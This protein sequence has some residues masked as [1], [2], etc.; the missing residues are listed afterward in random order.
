MSNPASPDGKLLVFEDFLEHLRRQG[1]TIGVDHYLRLQH[2]LNRVSDSCAPSDLKTLLCPILA[3]SQAEQEQFYRAFDT[4]F[5]VFHPTVPEVKP[6]VT[7]AEA[8][9]KVTEEPKLIAGKKWPY[10]LAGTLVVA[11]VFTLI[12]FLNQPKP[13]T[14]RPVDV[15]EN[16]Q[17]NTNTSTGNNQGVPSPKPGDVPADDTINLPLDTQPVVK[18]SFYERYGSA[19]RVG[20]IIVPVVFFLFYEWYRFNRRKLLLQKQRG[21]KPPYVWPLR[22]QPPPL[23]LYDSA[24]F[25]TT[26]RLMRRRQVGEFQRLDVYGTVMATINSLG[27]PNFRYKADSKYPEYL[28]LIDRAS[29][30]D[31]QAQ[32]FNQLAKALE[33]EAVFVSR[34]FYD[35][36][37]RVCRNETG[38]SF[39]LEE[40]RNKHVGQRLLIFGNGEKI[41]DPLTGSLTAWSA[42]FSDWPDRAV[43]TPELPSQWGLREITLAGQFIL[44]PATVDGLLAVVDHFESTLLTDLRSWRQ[45]GV[46]LPPRELDRPGVAEALRRYLGEETFNWLCACAVYPELHWDLTLYLGSLPCMP[47]GL[48]KEENLLRLIR[49]P[50]FRTGSMPDE[51]R[52]M[53]IGELD[54]EKEKVIRSAIINLLEKNPPAEGTVAADVYQL[55]LVV[56][57][58]LYRRE[59]KRLRELLRVLEPLPQNQVSRDYT[60]LRFLES[61]QN[62]PLHIFLPQQMRR[63]FYRNGIPVFGLKTVTRFL[64]TLGFSAVVALL[65]Y[66]DFYESAFSPG[67]ISLA[68]AATVPPS[69]PIA[70]KANA[71]SCSNCHGVTKSMQDKCIGCHTTQEFVPV[72][73]QSHAREKI[74]CTSCHIEHQGSS[75]GNG[76]LMMQVCTDC[77]NGTYTIKTG[78]RAGT[79]LPIAHGGD[80]G[81]PVEN[82]KWK[83]RLSADELRARGLPET[84]AGAGWDPDRQFHTIHESGRM[85]GRMSCKDC[86]TAGPVGGAVFRRTPREV[87]ATC[88]NITYTDQGAERVKSNCYT[89]HREHGTRSEDLARL[90]EDGKD[91]RKL[92]D[93]VDKLE[94]GILDSNERLATAGVFVEAGGAG[95]IRQ[96]R[97]AFPGLA[98]SFGGMTLYVWAALIGIISI[99]VLLLNRIKGSTYKHGSHR[100][101]THLIF[102]LMVLLLTAVAILGLKRYGLGENLLGLLNMRWILGIV[103]L[104]CIPVLM[105]YPVGRQTLNRQAGLSRYWRLAHSYLGIIASII[106]ILHSGADSGGLLTKALLTS[107]Y[108]MVF[109]GLLAIL[110]STR[111]S[112]DDLMLRRSELQEKLA[113]V[114]SSSKR[115]KR[116][117]DR[118]K[119]NRVIEVTELP[120]WVS[121][122]IY[123]TRFR[124]SLLT[125]HSLFIFLILALM[126]LHIIQVIYYAPR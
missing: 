108:A 12:V 54:R 126:L 113:Q 118:G 67:E 94:K 9:P 76:L 123:L 17:T 26:A 100:V 4:Y 38:D 65:M 33:A 80:I 8:L 102:I 45:S 72:V 121:A 1:F 40:L 104:I 68:H 103:G 3:T 107:W 117:E 46:K 66:T 48:V 110:F 124:K 97:D 2:L 15:T 24:P 28:I 51:V 83:W 60:L 93:Y 47:E 19:I 49:L 41:I 89:C 16:N 74:V 55:N 52:W 122:L 95:T 88:H 31:H 71:N 96:E 64:V 78:E 115:L 34:Y 106:I 36:D 18:K 81:Y 22:V 87:C 29:L 14:A 101:Q 20:A 98:S 61:A 42:T 30:R 125:A 7:A 70:L 37:P 116:K 120:R 43:L 50:W 32:L 21:K 105:A 35:G 119:L 69:R 5:A 62:S 111:F 114:E 79:I 53:L 109:T 13:E 91:E 6:G 112:R 82:G 59:R 86:H 10:A 57:R 11:L 44:M 85:N 39:H 73:F 75:S 90:L 63:L 56:Q 25:Y 99:A 58:W 23:K 27:Y 77:H 92:I 84:W